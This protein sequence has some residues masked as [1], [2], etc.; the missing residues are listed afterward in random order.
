MSLIRT[1]TI[2]CPA[3]ENQSRHEIAESVNADRRPDLRDAI[4]DDSF[5]RI[6]CP[7]CGGAL[8]FSPHMT[9]FDSERHQWI[10]A[11]PA[12]DRPIWES[13]E[14][15]ALDIFNRGFG[16]AAPRMA[17]SLGKTLTSRV[18]F[19]WSGL[20]EKLLCV[21]FG[22]NDADLELL[23]VLLMG[24]VESTHVR[25]D[26]ALRLIGVDASGD[27]LIGWVSDDN[28]SVDETLTVPRSLLGDIASDPD[29]WDALRAEIANGSFVDATKLLVQ[30]ELPIAD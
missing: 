24:T 1:Q 8:R 29:A 27:L 16:P 20:R 6:I 23:K 9:Y 14:S 5:Q 30:P 17:Q 2:T 7:V 26:A 22:V 13:F 25:D 10:L 15:G 28:E 11:L 18:T 4:L 12:H 3:C 19:G 21:Q